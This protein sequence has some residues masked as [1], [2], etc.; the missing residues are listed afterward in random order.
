MQP[1]EQPPKVIWIRSTEACAIAGVSQH[2][3]RKLASKGVLTSRRVGGSWTSYLRDEIEAI[4][5]RS[6]SRA[7][8]TEAQL[9]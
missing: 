2:Y 4:A 1:A 9:V 3:L 8:T 5:E 6:I 7:R